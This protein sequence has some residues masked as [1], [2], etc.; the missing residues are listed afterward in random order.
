MRECDERSVR[1]GVMRECDERSVREGVMRGC[2]ERVC[3]ERCVEI[4]FV[5]MGGVT[6]GCYDR[7]L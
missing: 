7:V 4:G 5:G 1:E 2:D 3:D 6:I